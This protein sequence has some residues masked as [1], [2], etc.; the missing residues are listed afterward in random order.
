MRRYEPFPF[1][2][3]MAFGRVSTRIATLALPAR[4]WSARACS[5]RVNVLGAGFMGV[6]PS[7]GVKCCADAIVD[8][9]LV[10]LRVSDQEDHG[11]PR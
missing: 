10:A 9:C 11:G 8:A 5:L 7:A 4:E 2:G 1:F 6:A 3:S